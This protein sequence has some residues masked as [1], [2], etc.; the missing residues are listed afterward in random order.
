MCTSNS[1]LASYA[2]PD[3][4]YAALFGLAKHRFGWGNLPGA[5]EAAERAIPVG[6]T[7][8][9][10]AEAIGILAN[11]LTQMSRIDEAILHLDDALKLDLPA[12]YKANI[13]GTRDQLA[14]Q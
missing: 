12:P 4:G 13:Q 10:K 5:V 2:A 3:A 14:G 6:T 7:D 9:E 1:N 8:L 11:A